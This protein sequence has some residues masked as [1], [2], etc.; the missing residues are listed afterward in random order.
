M[1]AIVVVRSLDSTIGCF[2]PLA[3]C[4]TPSGT[5]EARLHG[6]FLVNS[7]SAFPSPV[8]Q[9]SGAFS[10]RASLTLSFGRQLGTKAITCAVW[11]VSCTILIS[12]LNRSFSCLG[13]QFVNL[14][15]LWGV[16]SA[17]GE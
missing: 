14:W 7:S 1:L 2:P 3:A 13:L 5:V 8:S 12:N 11:G 16:L 4:M 15:L 6:D 10:S 17:N 9:V